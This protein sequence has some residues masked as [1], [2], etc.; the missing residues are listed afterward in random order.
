MP[1]DK[2]RRKCLQ[3]IT[4]IPIRANVKC[5]VGCTSCISCKLTPK[6]ETA[7]ENYF[8]DNVNFKDKVTL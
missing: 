7:S 3:N 6:L 5:T 4:D 2:I 8:N 1:N